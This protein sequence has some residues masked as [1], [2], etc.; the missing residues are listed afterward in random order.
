VD[1][2]AKQD[3]H[4][5]HHREREEARKQLQGHDAGVRHMQT[6]SQAQNLG[7]KQNPKARGELYQPGG[8]GRG[9]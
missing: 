4:E 7:S 3:D 9:N 1:K 5:K 8:G 6:R 2:V